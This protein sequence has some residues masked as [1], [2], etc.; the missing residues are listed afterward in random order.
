MSTHNIC[1]YKEVVKRKQAV[2]CL[3][4]FLTAHIGR[5][6][7]IKLIIVFLCKREHNVDTLYDSLIET[8][9]MSIHNVCL[10]EK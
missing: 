3:R 4:N 7:V 6:A 9:L 10:H 8:I 1:F 2:V 5:C